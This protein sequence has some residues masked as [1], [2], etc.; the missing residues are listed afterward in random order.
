MLVAHN[1]HQ[2]VHLQLSAWKPADSALKRVTV[3][4]RHFQAVV[5]V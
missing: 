5:Y 2:L 4:G 1:S 3:N